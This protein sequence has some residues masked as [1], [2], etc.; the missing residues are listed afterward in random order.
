MDWDTVMHFYGHLY[1]ISEEL[2]TE[3]LQALKFLCL[4]H[5]PLRKLEGI[6]HAQVLFLMLHEN[7]LIHEGDLSFLHELLFRIDRID[8]LKSNLGVSK[9]VVERALQQSD[10][11]K[12]SRY[13]H[14]LFVLSENMVKAD[15]DHL[16][17]LTDE[18]P[19]S[20]IGKDTTSLDI[21]VEMEKKGI[22]SEDNLDILK[23][24]CEKINKELLKIIEDFQVNTGV[25]SALQE[26]PSR[27]ESM[28]V[29]EN[30]C[31]LG[32]SSVCT[33]DSPAL[34]VGLPEVDQV[35]K[36]SSRPRGICLILNNK[37][38]AMARAQIPNPR[39]LKDRLGTDVDAGALSKAF[40]MLHFKIE[41]CKDLTAEAIKKTVKDYG[42]M[43]HKDS[44]C[45]VCCV[46]SHG[47]KGTIQGTDG[48]AIGI[49]KLTSYFTGLK[50][51]SLAGKPKVFFIQACQGDSFHPGVTLEADS[52]QTMPSYETDSNSQDECIPD[53]ADF[54]LGMATIKHYVSYR[55]TSSGT[56][57]IQSLC[58]HLM[59]SCQ[60]GDD[61][62]T[63]LTRVNQEVS[64]K[65]D[66]KNQGKQMPQPTFTLRKKL[67]F[68]VN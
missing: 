38:F 61:I 7:G 46:L 32:M 3:N 17:F 60:R 56:W 57:Y 27:K 52:L 40:S 26:V 31:N 59:E 33:S 66:Q 67:I 68:P 55:N 4:G 24:K 9:D 53:E 15:L 64:A 30:V 42:A 25:K 34:P 12:V 28:G 23:E 19:K 14:M 54:L 39:T 41:E 29:E 48:R 62:L 37:N 44:D 47:D 20:K 2:D 1:K 50:C 6:Q 10:R 65:Y 35:Y 43:S 11:R 22:L 36:M 51:P 58:K 45:F 5:I 21:F 8:L 18:L 63:I 16:K 13:R 49:R